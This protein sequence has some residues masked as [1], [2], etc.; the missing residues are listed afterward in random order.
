MPDPL[1]GG[2][3]PL[4]RG[5]APAMPRH[6]DEIRGYEGQ[7]AGYEDA[8]RVSPVLARRSLEGFVRVQGEAVEVEAIVPVCV[9]DEGEPVGP[10][11]ISSLEE[12]PVQMFVE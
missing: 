6:D 3:G 2:G 5:I 1:Q 9:A 12:G 10:K 11:S 8:L 4:R 7:E